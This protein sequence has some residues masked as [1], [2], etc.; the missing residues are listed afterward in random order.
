MKKTKQLYYKKIE[1]ITK[2]KKRRLPHIF[3]GLISL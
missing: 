2:K 1:R 3:L